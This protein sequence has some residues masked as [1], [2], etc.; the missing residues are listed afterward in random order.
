MAIQADRTSPRMHRFVTA[1]WRSTR[2]PRKA[3][4]HLPSLFA[5][6]LPILQSC[7]FASASRSTFSTRAL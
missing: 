5:L 6:G 2:D 3:L 4:S 7:P 1:L